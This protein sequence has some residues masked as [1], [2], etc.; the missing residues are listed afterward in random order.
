MGLIQA[1]YML[2]INGRRQTGYWHT[3]FN[4]SSLL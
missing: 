2:G 3:C 1:M 4:F